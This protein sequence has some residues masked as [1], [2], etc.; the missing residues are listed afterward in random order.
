M[1][2]H[3]PLPVA[4]VALL[5][6]TAPMAIAVAQ[7]AQPTSSAAASQPAAPPVLIPLQFGDAVLK[8]AGDLFAKAKLPDGGERLEIVIDPLIDGMSGAQTVATRDIGNRLAEFLKQKEPR[9]DLRPFSTASVA[10]A[11]YLLIG[12]FT[13]IN[14]DGQ[15]NGPRDAF[16]F[17]LALADLKTG[18]VVGK[19][20][21]RAKPDG[22]DTSPT[23]AFNDAAVWMKDPAVEG[24]IKTCQATKLGENVDQVYVAKLQTA[25]IVSDAILA[26]ERG[27]FADSLQL[28]TAALG[29]NGGEQLRVLNGVYLTNWKLNRRKEA[30]E[31]CGRLVDYGIKS[32]RLAV[33]F[34]FRPGSTRFMDDARISAPYPLWLQQIATRAVM[35]NACLEIVGHTSATGQAAVNERL[36]A[37]RAEFISDR[38]SAH[39]PMLRQ[40]MIAHGAGSRENLIGTGKDNASDALD[41]RVEFKVIKCGNAA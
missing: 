7:T 11:P 18:K 21:A 10:N 31:A 40:R 26:Y 5:I 16:R 35:N 12:T 41:R 29:S 30:A 3:L 19:G 1:P 13:A 4:F 32:E 2:K 25:A 9:F 33:K 6:I 20:V 14:T 17:C 36:S 37:L 15:A 38:L 23:A 22:V 24:Y 39:A 27:R 28:Y 34:L 8:A